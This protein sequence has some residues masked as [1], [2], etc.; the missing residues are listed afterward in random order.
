MSGSLFTVLPL[1]IATS[2][3]IHIHGLFSLSPDRA[4]LHQNERIIQDQ[5][6]A[7]WNKWLFELLIP[8]AWTKL[9]GYLAQIYAL[10][11]AFSRWPRTVDD[12]RDPLNNSVD[13]V[14]KI[15]QQENLPLWPTT[16]GYVSAKAG[17]LYVDPDS[18]SL[19]EAFE[20]AGI[21][22]VYV[23]EELQQLARF[24]FKD[25]IL[26]P[27]SLCVFL[28]TQSARIAKFSEPTK[29]KLVEYV[30][31]KPGF[32][33]YDGL[34]IFPFMDGKYRSLGDGLSFVHRD[35]LEEKLFCL[36]NSQNLDLKKLSKPAQVAL[37]RRCEHMNTQSTICYRSATSLK[38]Y[39]NATIFQNIPKNEDAVVLGNEALKRISDIWT[40]ISLRGINVLDSEI[41]SL[42]LLP[43]SNGQYRKITPGSS[44]S[45]V[46]IAPEGEVGD[47]M[48]KFDCRASTKLVPLLDTRVVYSKQVLSCITF[49]AMSSMFIRN[50]SGVLPFISWLGLTMPMVPD[51]SGE[52]RFHILNIIASK[53]PQ[54]FGITAHSGIGAYFGIGSALAP[55]E[56]FQK[57]LWKVEG[58]QMFANHFQI[59][60]LANCE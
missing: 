8:Q 2:Q 26:E 3:P 52:E 54:D 15:I 44:S 57:V 49:H 34:E 45:F 55:L 10:E 23:P 31:S 27:E 50:A 41:A 6:P 60:F 59:L 43:L 32:V 19:R 17:M 28:R 33:G 38:K 39:C 56:I 47:L 12:S 11:P 25:R 7:E 29:H 58:D 21:P 51:V 24:S 5:D 13:N 30:L 18:P 20:E 9:L 35:K 46:Y 22:V 42:W 1:P 36:E 53:L 37:R 40:W 4:R 16:I 48:W 14:L